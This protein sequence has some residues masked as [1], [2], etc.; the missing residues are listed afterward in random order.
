MKETYVEGWL[1]LRVES[2]DYRTNYLTIF[3]KKYISYTA[4]ARRHEQFPSYSLSRIPTAGL[5][6]D[7]TVK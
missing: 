4:T 1:M 3:G 6:P 5:R 7:L 2:K